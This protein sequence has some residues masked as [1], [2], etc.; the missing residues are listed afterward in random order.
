ML[1]MRVEAG[2]SRNAIWN[3]TVWVWL[4]DQPGQN[5]NITI[6]KT[7][8]QTVTNSIVLVNDNSFSWNV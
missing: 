4:G 2:Q 8:D 1:G 5:G 6:K 3:G 7:A